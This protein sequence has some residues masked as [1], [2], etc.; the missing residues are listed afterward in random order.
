VID[1]AALNAQLNRDMY[2]YE[3][4]RPRSQQG[5]SGILGPSDIGFCRQKALLTVLE[6]EPTDEQSL[7]AAQVGTAVGNYW[8][9]GLHWAHPGW[10]IGSIHNKRVTA[11]LPSG[12]EISGTPD[13]IAPDLNAIIDIKTKDGLEIIKRSGTSLDNRYQRHLYGLGALAAGYLDPD[14]PVYVGNY[15]IDRA[16]VDQP[17]L[18]LEEMDPTLTIEIDSWV[19]DVIYARI[20]HEDAS[21]DIPSPV[22]E[23]IC[24]FFTICRGGLDNHEGGDLIEDATLIQAIDIYVEARDLIKTA[25]KQKKE[26]AAVLA[27]VNGTDGRFQVRW[28]FVNPSTVEA[29]EK[30][31]YE[32]LDIRAQRK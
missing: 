11:V 28:T 6:T 26:A 1:V 13:I 9:E 10:I 27:G 5:R 3:L 15:Y 16:G 4:S 2:D 25:E 22:C 19:Q 20:N 21:R 30:R 24:R 31:G 17:V 29:F 14:Q 8:E 7:L 12:V 23:R 32:R 18:L